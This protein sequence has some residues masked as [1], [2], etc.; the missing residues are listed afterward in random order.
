MATITTSKTNG[1]A[2]F[3]PE[4]VSEMFDNVKGHSTIA[5]LCAAKPLPF[6]GIEMFTFS[7]DGEV[8]IV[9]EGGA[10]PAGEAAFGKIMI[11]PIKVVY[12]HRVTDEFVHMAKEK[13][14]PYMRAFSEGFAKKIARAIDICSVHGLNPADRTASAAIGDNCFDKSAANVVA[15]NASYPD[16][17]IDDAA[18]L[19][20]D[21][22][23]NMT[24]IAMTPAFGSALGAMKTADSH[25]PI[26]PEYRFGANPGKFGGMTADINNTIAFANSDDRAIVGDFE[27]AFRWGYSENVTFEVIEYGDPDG[28]GD[29]KRNNQVC[30]RSEAYIGWG[31]LDPTHFAIIKVGAL[32]GLTVT[33]CAGTVDMWGTLVSQLQS[34]VTV[35]GNRICGTLH[36]IDSG[37]LATDWG[38]GNFLALQ[39]SGEDASATS[40]KVGLV[41]SEGTGLVELHGD[42]DMNGVFKITDKDAQ[43]FKIVTTDGTHT[44]TQ[45]FRLGGLTCESA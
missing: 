42:P 26:Y 2:L 33:A 37:A 18:R 36:Y 21:A 10:K 43:R 1:S 14:L 13:Q 11:K 28:Q 3:T 20:M 8:S 17:C 16:D 30:L 19:I 7:M 25:L 34:N 9:G 39:F 27:N 29:L 35:E 45:M 41:P 22:D 38:A 12:Q 44:T 23:G 24:G 32:K 40:T 4:L 6:S 5:K 31:I 15:Y